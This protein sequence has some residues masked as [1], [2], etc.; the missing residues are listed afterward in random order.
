MWC[1]L[2]KRSR[3]QTFTASACVYVTDTVDAF[4]L[5]AGTQWLEP[6]FGAL[7]KWGTYA[8]L[9]SFRHTTECDRWQT[10]P[11]LY[12]TLKKNAYLLL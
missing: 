1:Y 6:A 3:S 7:F 5:E 9:I 4:V 10:A 8:A 11:S 2:I 12:V